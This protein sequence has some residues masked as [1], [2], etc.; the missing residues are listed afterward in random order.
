MVMQGIC[1]AP[2][3]LPL[4]NCF[5]NS[6]WET[7]PINN[8]LP[9]DYPPPRNTG[10]KSVALRVYRDPTMPR[11]R[12]ARGRS[13]AAVTMDWGESSK[14]WGQIDIDQVRRRALYRWRFCFD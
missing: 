6:I 2:K 9:R 3:G 14:G 13:V 1:A 5:I 7:P 4:R 8:Q 11:L 12:G 10:Y